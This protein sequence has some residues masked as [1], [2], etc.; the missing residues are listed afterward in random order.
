MGITAM[1]IF[2]TAFEHLL[3][4]RTMKIIQLI[5]TLRELT[6]TVNYVTAYSLSIKHLQ[7]NPASYQEKKWKWQQKTALTD[8]GFEL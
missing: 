1:E 3:C 8:V 2:C 6:F 5:D 4:Y 7:L